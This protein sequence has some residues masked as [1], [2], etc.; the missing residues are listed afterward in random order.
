[1]GFKMKGSE[2][3]GHLKLNR[4]MDNTSKPDGRPNSSAFQKRTRTV[5]ERD[6]YMSQQVVNP[7]TGEKENPKKDVLVVKNKKGETVREKDISAKRADRI[8]R[9]Q[10]RRAVRK[11]ARHDVRQSGKNETDEQQ[12]NR[13]EGDFPKD[14][15][16]QGYTGPSM[17][18]L[19]E[20]WKITDKA[21]A[22]SGTEVTPE[23]IAEYKRKHNLP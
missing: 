10:A 14:F 18:E 8:R 6:D 5:E 22:G 2:F 4:N 20:R 15:G 19:V 11:D 12:I 7:R 21:S 16:K 1:M 3:Y 9:R 17:L 13:L 23:D